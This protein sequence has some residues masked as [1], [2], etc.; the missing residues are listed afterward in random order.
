MEINIKGVDKMKLLLC[1]WN[2]AK[3]AAYWDDKP[4]KDRPIFDE[5]EAQ[6]QIDQYIEYLCGKPIH[7][8]LNKDVVNV[9]QYDHHNGQNLFAKCLAKV[10]MNTGSEKESPK[11]KNYEEK[12]QTCFFEALKMPLMND[13][14]KKCGKLKN[15]HEQYQ[16]QKS[17]NA[18]PTKRKINKKEEISNENITVN[19]YE[20]KRKSCI[21]KAFG[22]G[23][24]MLA[25]DPG[26]VMCTFCGHFKKHHSF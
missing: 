11:Q 6:E 18:Q 8:N 24:P 21:F 25:N 20:K 13:I 12:K 3:Y 1:L 16:T 15:Q 2:E 9:K 26:T 22:D 19:L 4:H 5:T 17:N 23:K 10:M 7:C 14:C